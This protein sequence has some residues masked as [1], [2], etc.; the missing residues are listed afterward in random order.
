M[1]ALLLNSNSHAICSHG[2]QAKPVMPAVRVKLSGSPAVMQQPPW[3]VSGCL[4][5][6]MFGAGPTGQMHTIVGMLPCF[7]ANWMTATV[8]V[9]S[10]GQ[11][12]LLENSQG[13]A[14]PSGLPVVVVPNQFRVRAI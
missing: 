10:M 6:P 11:P 12:L 2:G 5:P 4:L 3:P 7:F 13:I 1:A 8:R 14:I 9:K